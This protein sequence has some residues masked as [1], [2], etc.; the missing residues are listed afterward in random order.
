MSVQTEQ[1]VNEDTIW[2]YI[3]T[4]MIPVVLNIGVY[5]NCVHMF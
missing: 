4:E 5:R 2:M 1:T 3:S